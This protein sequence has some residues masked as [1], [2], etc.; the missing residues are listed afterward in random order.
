MSELALKAETSVLVMVTEADSL[1]DK[2]PKS[3]HRLYLEASESYLRLSRAYPS[4]E[5][6][7]VNE[8]SALYMKAQ[9]LKNRGNLKNQARAVNQ[10][11]IL[12]PDRSFSDVA[13]LESVKDDIKMKIIAPFR[14]PDIFRYYGK[15]AGGGILMYGPPGCGKTLLAEAAAGEAGLLFFHVK[16]SD[17]KS[18]YVGETE[19]NIAELFAQAREQSPCIIFFDEIEAL[20]QDRNETNHIGRGFVSQLLTE[21]DGVGTKD[22]KVLLLAATNMPWM[23]DSALLRNGR[24]GTSIFV[25]PPDK[26]GRLGILR[27][28][29]KDKPMESLDLSI[30][31]DATDG[32]SGADMHAVCNE[33]LDILI[34][35]FFKNGKKRKIEYRDF[36]EVLAKRKSSVIPWFRKAV[37]HIHRHQLQDYYGDVMEYVGGKDAGR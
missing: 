18:K 14:N 22:S 25:P 9:S 27:M 31:A 30:I 20:G 24:F 17:L 36:A 3:A 35:E 13:G 32:F 34:K 37:E 19:K 11:I 8:A 28:F 10:A 15:K 6:R 21:M 29:L 5:S 16:A 1:R 12:P 7:L 23:V 4:H 33:V 26:V 2:D